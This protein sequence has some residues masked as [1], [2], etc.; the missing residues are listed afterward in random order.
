[1]IPIS[2]GDCAASTNGNLNLAHPHARPD[3]RKPAGNERGADVGLKD[4]A[5]VINPETLSASI[6]LFG[7]VRVSLTRPRMMA[8][9][10]RPRSDVP[11]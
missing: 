6:V 4:R 3:L 9:R 2:S 7:C 10:D 8:P 1:M 11:K 5:R